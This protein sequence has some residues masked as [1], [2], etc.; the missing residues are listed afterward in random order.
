[1]VRV[2]T[3]GF[4]NSIQDLGRTGYRSIGVPSSGAMD[5]YSARL[6]NHLLNNDESD[7]VLEITLGSCKLRFD[8]PS[9]ISLTGADF[10]AKCNNK[11]VPL[12]KPFMVKKGYVLT[13][14]QRIYGVR[15][16]LAIACG[17][18][19]EECLGSRSWYKHV[20]KHQWL[21]KQMIIPYSESHSK[22]Q[23]TLSLLK[24]NHDHFSSKIIKCNP[25]PEFDL[26]TKS[27]KQLLFGTQ[28]SISTDNNRMGYKLEGLL[29]NNF[30]SMLTSAVLP[31][32]VQLTPSGKLIVLMRDCQVTGGY[33]RILQLT[34]QAI[35]NLAQ[36]S[37]GDSV[38]FNII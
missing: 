4:F 31:G 12:N 5:M 1:M 18:Q 14:G 10:S 25:G 24:V 17:F 22:L 13:F 29:E 27:Q 28:F 9:I 11:A 16:Y 8:K 33:P 30:P 34:N 35:N 36:K 15:T 26:L 32:T 7:A 6:A 23:S 19:T 3:A 37:S 21:T 38:F 2:I 20:T